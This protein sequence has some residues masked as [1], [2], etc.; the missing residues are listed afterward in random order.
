MENEKKMNVPYDPST[1]IESYFEQIED[2]VEF[3]AAENSPFSTI[4][5]VTKAFI[6]MFSTG[7]YIDKCKACNRLPVVSCDWVTFKLI[8]AAAARELHEMQALS[9]NTG[10]VNN[11]QQDT[12]NQT[13][14]VL[15]NLAKS[16]TEDRVTVYNVTTA[17]HIL[18]QQLARTTDAHENEIKCN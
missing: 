17:N 8:F 13:S 9:G 1:D 10:Y 18:T 16:T 5:I 12:T 3:A 7:L 11:V 2:A 4:Q 6:Q 15:T 14:L